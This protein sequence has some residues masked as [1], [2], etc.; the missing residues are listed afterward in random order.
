MYNKVMVFNVDKKWL[1]ENGLISNGKLPPFNPKLLQRAKEHRK[2]MTK[3]EQKLWF[4]FLQKHPVKFQRQKVID[5]YIVDFYCAKTRLIIEV[6]GSYHLLDDQVS[7]DNIR[8]DRLN[9]YNLSVVRFSNDD[10]LNNFDFVCSTIDG[11]IK[12][13]PL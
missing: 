12:S 13:P 4:Q 2:N 5:H 8:T 10:V 3:S 7:Y 6:D 9:L 1:L 11:L